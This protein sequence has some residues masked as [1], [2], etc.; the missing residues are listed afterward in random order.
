MIN[1]LGQKSSY[2]K[3]LLNCITQCEH[4]T[5]KPDLN[6]PCFNILSQQSVESSR[7]V[8]EPWRGDL[9]AP[10]LFISSNPSIDT[11]DDCPT[12][13][14]SQ[15]YIFDYYNNNFGEIFPKLRNR[16]GNIREKPV[17]Y[18]INI[19]ARAA[20]IFGEPP[21][22][23]FPGKD[24]SITEVVHCKSKNEIG[25]QGA[26]NFCKDKF[27]QN[28]IDTSEAKI[29]VAVG[30]KAGEALGIGFGGKG[31]IGKRSS[32]LV[33]IPHPNAFQK[34]KFLNHYSPKDEI[35]SILKR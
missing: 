29:V 22:K 8:P 6:H 25:V 3:T 32:I 34:K 28:I 14:E 15:E 9:S 30:R 1:D 27:L 33:S 13:G 5:S 12:E 35:F 31:S 10:I 26:V 21:R 4:F 17:R 2:R 20:E 7:Q 18:W 19:R 23:V 11:E 24:F 16:D